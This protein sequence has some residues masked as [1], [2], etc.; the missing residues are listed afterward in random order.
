MF[1]DDLKAKGWTE[2]IRLQE[3]VKGD[4][5]IGFDTGH[6]MI[7]ETKNNP[8]VSDVPLP[9]DYT[10]RWTV[11]LIEHL[12]RMEDER[13]RLRKALETIR[14]DPACGE[15]GRSAAALALKECYHRCLVN[16]EIPKGQKGRLYCCI[17]GY[18]AD[19]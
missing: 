15:T 13:N 17:C 5:N 6:W 14:D 16:L 10:S 1:A 9:D 3:Y 12:C 11:N 7:V 4:W 19:E 8:R 2:I 18:T